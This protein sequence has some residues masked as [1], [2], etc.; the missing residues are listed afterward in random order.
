[1][2]HLLFFQPQRRRLFEQIITGFKPIMTLD[3]SVLILNRS[4]EGT[5]VGMDSRGNWHR[6]D[7]RKPIGLTDV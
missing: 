3:Q 1:V 2:N 6:F 5:Q 7:C 4:H